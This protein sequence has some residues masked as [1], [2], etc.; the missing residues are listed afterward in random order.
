ML[1][2]LRS[3]L[4][5]LFLRFRFSSLFLCICLAR[6]SDNLGFN[7]RIEIHREKETEWDRVKEL[8][9]IFESHY[10]MGVRC[11]QMYLNRLCSR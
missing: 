9:G 6:C 5:G 10:S 3:V 1:K 4:V 2:S 8:N 11:I 7:L